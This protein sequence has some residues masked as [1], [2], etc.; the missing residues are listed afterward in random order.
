[1][2]VALDPRDFQV[3][4]DNCDREPIH[5]SGA[6]Q[7]HGVLFVVDPQTLEIRQLSG[8]AGALWAA[9]SRQLLGR[10]LAG[11]LD[12]RAVAA[13]RQLAAADE[14]MTVNPLQ[15]TTLA[16]A[17]ATF[18]V[19]VHRGPEGLLVE[20]EPATRGALSF[21]DFY[22]RA[23]LAVARL[24]SVTGVEE[25]CRKAADEVRALTGFDRVMVYRF[26]RHDHG[27]VIAETKLEEL[28]PF[29]DLHYPASDI[30]AQARR[31]YTVNRL[32][33][34]V[35][36]T[37]RPVPI[38]PAV[39]PATGEPLDLS[40]SVLRSVSPIHTEYL[41]NMGVAASMS[42]SLVIDGRL[43]GLVICHHN[44]PKLVPYDVR[45]AC[46]FLSQTLSWHLA[47]SER[48]DVMEC[49]SQG[50]EHL[51]RLLHILSE[52][53]DLENGLFLAADPLL[54]LVAAEGAALHHAGRLTLL[55][56]TPAEGL[57]QQLVHWLRQRP[58]G[59]F[60]T[61]RLAQELPAAR[62]AIPVASGLLAVRLDREGDSV[63]LWFRPEALQTVRWAGDPNKTV[64]LKDGAPRL[65]PRGS[66]ALWKETVREQSLPWQPWEIDLAVD[67][68]HAVASVV[69]KQAVA[70]EHLNR[71]LRATSEALRAASLAKD[72]F[73]AT[74]SHELRNPLN[75]MLGWLRLLRTQSLDAARS[76][77]ALEV[78]ERNAQAQAKLIED[79]LDVSRIISGKMR[80][81]VQPVNLLEVV[82]ATLDGVLPSAEAKSIRLHS[83]L[84]PAAS[85]ILGDA[86]RLQQVVWNLLTNAIKFTPKG[87]QVQM[88][89]T[90]NESS[91]SISVS[92]SGVGIDSELLPYVFERFRQGHS[93]SAR[94][95]QGLGLG[96]AIVRHLV[97]LHGGR[98]VAFSEGTGRGAVFTLHLPLAPVRLQAG[99]PLLSVEPSLCPPQLVGL[100]VLL[101]E[102]EPD[103]RELMA[104]EL[105]R[106]GVIVVQAVGGAAEA[107]QLLAESPVDVVISDIGMPEMDGY[108]FLKT[109]RQRPASQGGHVP[110]IALTA[111]AS[112]QDRTRAFLAGFQ[113]HLPKPIEPA[114]LFALLVSVS[115]RNPA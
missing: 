97:E 23:R 83:V 65:S 91:A 17:P 50:D 42:I 14:A 22:Y 105:S 26:D 79:L 74:V 12:E 108:A 25:L 15:A 13:L 49:R 44:S 45:A 84:D 54:E 38:E 98:V 111:Y 28:E 34:I 115:G 21:G 5:L 47:A 11:L 56:S 103:A 89:L 92:D 70:F 19:I 30:P 93:G 51:R 109:L 27:H 88:H 107:L 113:A 96:L 31:L 52:S 4:L 73:L 20:L 76:T 114:E 94:T 18:D 48:A 85:L 3:D 99:V 46:D 57:V 40:F 59:L 75:A 68:G 82:R 66:F 37:Y 8:N 41:Q 72:D 64:S 101:V 35:D 106:C 80:L 36:V 61:D 81:D 62:T 10:S 58:A 95:H 110:A 77:Q 71:E 53:G 102:D 104:V 33:M 69:L 78:I 90:R 87:G 55:G 7:P 32:R 39:S 24:Q 63:L 29:L 6:I 100:R 2:S 9:E 67:F 16:A 86:A 60:H 43:W 1:M 112:S